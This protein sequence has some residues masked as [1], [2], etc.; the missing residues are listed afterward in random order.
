MS[1]PVTTAALSSPTTMSCRTAQ[2]TVNGKRWYR[3]LNGSYGFSDRGS[4][5]PGPTLLTDSIGHGPDRHQTS[6]N[7]GSQ[8]SVVGHRHLFLS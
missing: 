3:N 5:R 6:V 2:L 1:M 7:V 8:S 4:E